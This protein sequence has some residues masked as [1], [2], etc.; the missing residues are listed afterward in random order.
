MYEEKSLYNLL[1]KKPIL[2]LMYA[3]GLL[4]LHAFSNRKAMQVGQR[5]V[6]LI[7]RTHS[8]EG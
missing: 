8:A 7:Y 1:K 3:L 2:K 4:L 6:R 5:D